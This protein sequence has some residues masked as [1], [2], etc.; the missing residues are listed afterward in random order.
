MKEFAKN[1][2]S[3]ILLPAAI[4]IFIGQGVANLISQKKHDKEIYQ[5]LKEAGMLAEDLCNK[6]KDSPLHK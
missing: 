5:T 1:L 6:G 4:V 2:G 3:I